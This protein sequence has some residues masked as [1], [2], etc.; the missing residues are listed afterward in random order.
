MWHNWPHW[1]SCTEKAQGLWGCQPTIILTWHSIDIIAS[2]KSNIACI[3]YEYIPDQNK[4]DWKDPRKTPHTWEA[5]YTFTLLIHSYSVCHFLSFKG[6]KASSSKGLLSKYWFYTCSGF[7]WLLQR[8]IIMGNK[9]NICPQSQERTNILSTS[10]SSLIWQGRR[11][12][13]LSAAH[14]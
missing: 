3:L 10:K 8:C 4:K 6:R 1:G 2:S 9:D 14:T 11:C 13:M 7:C 12:W 5:Q